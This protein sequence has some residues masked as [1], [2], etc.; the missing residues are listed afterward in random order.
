MS[1]NLAAE[2]APVPAQNQGARRQCGGWAGKIPPSPPFLPPLILSLVWQAGSS[3]SPPPGTTAGGHRRALSA[4]RGPVRAQ[5]LPSAAG[6]PRG[7]DP[8]SLR[9]AAEAGVCR[10]RGGVFAAS[11]TQRRAHPGDRVEE[12]GLGEEPGSRPR[13]RGSGS[14]PCAATRSLGNL[15][16]G[17]SLVKPR[18]LHV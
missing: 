14:S 1:G 3:P 9:P 18:F 5:H 12:G 15:R 16:R 6:P 8:A 4:P 17:F 13:R 7:R 11:R 2:G 10:S